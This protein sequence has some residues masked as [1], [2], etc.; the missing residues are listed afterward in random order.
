[1]IVRKVDNNKVVRIQL[2]FSSDQEEAFLEKNS[3]DG[4]IQVDS[5][6]ESLYE[7]WKIIDDVIVVD[8]EEESK[9]AQRQINK[10]ALE[11]LASTDWYEIRALRGIEIPEEIIAK[12]Q[13]ARDSIIEV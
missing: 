3:N 5:L 10:K 12:R 13:E 2:N 9:E 4:Y 11:Y 1:M 8:D 6:P 7:K